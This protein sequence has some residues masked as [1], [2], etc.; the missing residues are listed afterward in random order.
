MTNIHRILVFLL[1]VSFFSCSS[2]E[3][4]ENIE[5]DRGEDW[6]IIGGDPSRT[7]ISKSDSAFTPPFELYW[8]FNADA[9]FSNNCMSIS[10]AVLFAATL[11]GEVF[12]ID[13][14]S[15]KSLGRISN[16]GKA[17][18][19]TPLILKSGLIVTFDGDK[20]KSILSYD[21]GTGTEIWSRDIGMIR[22]SPVSYED[23]IFV[24]SI[25][26]KLYKMEPSTGSIL[27]S[28]T[29]YGDSIKLKSFYTSP[30]VYDSVVYSGNSNGYMYALGL[31]NGQTKWKFKTGASI[32]CDASIKDG[33]VYFGSD[34][35]SFYCIKPNGTLKWKRE[36]G[37]EFKASCTF[38]KD[39]VITAGV[40]GIIY[41]M[42]TEDG[43]VI[44]EYRTDG[45]IWASPVIQKD[46]IFIGSFDRKLYCINADNG[47]KL[48][49]YET[50]GRI[51]ASVVIWKNFIFAASDDR[52]IYCFGN[53]RSG[54]L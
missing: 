53:K 32:N 44:W 48:W 19:C 28:F 39:M 51:R 14:L 43:N 5:I 23:N 21:I 16:L 31:R 9:G 26:K 37:T 33:F 13:V 29:G 47:E 54:I 30:S 24:S 45:T 46:K 34:D 41:A 4:K 3:I 25:D 2:I 6:L 42:N 8:D 35:K 22:S 36:L 1:C 15:G 40:N 11:R 52:N 17:T 50:E 7:N 18:Y 20:K 10:D 27:W 12:A 38:Y 49:H